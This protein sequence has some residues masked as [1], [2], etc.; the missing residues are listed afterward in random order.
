MSVDDVDKCPATINGEHGFLWQ[1][2]RKQWVCSCGAIAVRNGRTQKQLD[3][4]EEG[5]GAKEVMGAIHD[6]LKKHDGI[7]RVPVM[8]TV[9][10]RA[11]WETVLRYFSP[12]EQKRIEAKWITEEDMA[13]SSADTLSWLGE[14]MSSVPATPRVPF[15]NPEEDFGKVPNGIRSEIV[16]AKFVILA[17][18]PMGPDIVGEGAQ[19]SDGSV[20]VNRIHESHMS[21][22]KIL[23]VSMEDV[24]I[25]EHCRIMWEDPSLHG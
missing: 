7:V 12:V 21:N 2:Q 19:F 22:V 16:F 5:M 13:R 3:F 20:I 10:G 6:A 17:D 25:G 8:D 23:Y 4:L 11:T 1:E 24:T 14:K 15:T 9:Q 18:G